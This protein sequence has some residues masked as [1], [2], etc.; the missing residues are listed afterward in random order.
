MDASGKEILGR[1]AEAGIPIDTGAS[2]PSTCN[3]PFVQLIVDLEPG[4][5]LVFGRFD[6]HILENTFD[7]TTVLVNYP[8]QVKTRT[9]TVR[10]RGSPHE[11]RTQ[12]RIEMYTER[13]IRVI[14]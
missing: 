11:W 12:R 9:S 5:S 7:G 14:R 2:T 3:G 8:E 6:L 10:D 13:F 1:A 4:A